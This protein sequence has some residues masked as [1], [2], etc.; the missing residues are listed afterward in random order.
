VSL[1]EFS[2]AG[3]ACGDQDRA[4]VGSWEEG[5]EVVSLRVF[6]LYMVVS[7]DVVK[8]DEPSTVSFESQPPENSVRALRCFFA[9]SGDLD[10]RFRY[11]VD[12]CIC[13]KPRQALQERVFA[14][15]IKPY[16]CTIA[17]LVFPGICDG[18]LGF[19]DTTET[20]EDVDLS[21]MRRG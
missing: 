9:M 7:I 11:T 6:D 21:S 19:A 16:D 18:Q 3:K 13:C 15:A 20:V 1:P 5:L 4:V 10:G 17:L 12:T 2:K 8:D 14:V